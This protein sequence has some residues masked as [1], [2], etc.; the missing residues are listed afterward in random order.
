MCKNTSKQCI[1]HNFFE[2]QTVEVEKH[3]KWWKKSHF[4][5][6][7][8][9]CILSFSCA[10]SIF[11]QD[12][13]LNVWKSTYF[14]LGSHFCIRPNLKPLFLRNIFLQKCLT[15]SWKFWNNSARKY[16]FTAILVSFKC[17]RSVLLENVEISICDFFYPNASMCHSVSCAILAE[18]VLWVVAIICR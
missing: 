9:I 18:L 6:I 10:M 15:W 14:Y 3:K 11:S 4:F 13:V 17:R 8:G 7:N 1:W 5:S 12:K 16:P 2:P